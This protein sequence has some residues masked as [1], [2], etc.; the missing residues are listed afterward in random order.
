VFAPFILLNT[1]TFCIYSG[2][3][4]L[5]AQTK[6]RPTVNFVQ[7]PLPDMT[8][9]EAR[10]EA[11]AGAGGGKN[12][13][14]GNRNDGGGGGGGGSDWGSRGGCPAPSTGTEPQAVVAAVAAYAQRRRWR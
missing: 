6:E 2:S 4:F 1:P 5:I 12:N 10:L 9:T 8:I 11:K 7:T 3:R 14:G 13:R